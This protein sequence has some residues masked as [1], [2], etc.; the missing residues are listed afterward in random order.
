MHIAQS[1]D[2]NL[3]QDVNE[4]FKQM[5]FTV[6]LR[7]WASVQRLLNTKFGLQ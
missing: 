5:P 7:R 3:D 4:A 2:Y 1:G 6:E